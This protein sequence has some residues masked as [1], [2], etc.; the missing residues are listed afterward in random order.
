MNKTLRTIAFKYLVIASIIGSLLTGCHSK[1][2][3]PD[4]SKID[5]NVK[6]VPFFSALTQLPVDSIESALPGLKKTYGNFLETY[7]QGI[8]NIGSSK[9]P[10]YPQYLKSFLEYDANRDVFRACDSAFTDLSN[11]QKSLNKAFS[12][13]NYYFPEKDIPAIYLHISGFNQSIVADS[14]LISLSIEKY[15]G[16]QCQFY[17]WLT[18]PKYLRKKMVP[19]KMVPDVMKAMAMIDFPYN[20]SINDVL[21]NM[22]YQGQVLHFIKKTNPDIQDTLLFDYSKSQLEW[23]EKHESEMWQFMVENKHLFNNERFIIQKY[24]GD[25]PFSYYLG[26]DSPG[27]AGIFLGYQIV[28]AYMKQSP[29]K[30]L[31]GLMQETDG[32]KIL[33]QSRYRP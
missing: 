27:R 30:S 25:S 23:C 20:D 33:T 31:K 14:G 22:I 16:E 12:Y 8:I 26:Q 18:I 32:H 17:E 5:V 15:L 13:Y 7:S 24:V 10:E 2:Q 9:A 3:R 21:N 29:K 11:L 1:A 28:N 6:L 4:I 19:E